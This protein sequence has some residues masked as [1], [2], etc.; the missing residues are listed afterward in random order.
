MKLREAAIEKRLREDVRRAGGW[1]VKFLPNHMKGMPDRLVIL[2]GGRCAW[3]ELKAPGKKVIAG[4]LQEKRRQVLEGLGH[5]VWEISSTDQI[6]EFIDAVF[7][8]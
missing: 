6:K 1:A 3:V 2:P 4:S 5:D 8:A 7:T